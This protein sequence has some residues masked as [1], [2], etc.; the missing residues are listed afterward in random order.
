MVCVANL[1]E[2]PYLHLTYFVSGHYSSAVSHNL[3]KAD[4]RADVA[5]ALLNGSGAG[6]R[7]AAQLAIFVPNSVQVYL[8]KRM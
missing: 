7:R 1:A 5:A 4:H 2:C 8:A 6:S 3:L